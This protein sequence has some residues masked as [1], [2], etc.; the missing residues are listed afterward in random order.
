MNR[1]MLRILRSLNKDDTCCKGS[2]CFFCSL[3]GDKIGAFTRQ[4]DLVIEPHSKVDKLAY[5]QC[6]DV[7]TGFCNRRMELKLLHFLCF[8]LSTLPF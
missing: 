2:R 7:P 1:R 3:R 8:E 4:Q 5:V 6:M